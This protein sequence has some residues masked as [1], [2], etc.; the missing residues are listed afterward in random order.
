MQGY[1]RGGINDYQPGPPA[2]W[3]SMPQQPNPPS[4]YPPMNQG[5]L[6]ID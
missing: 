5:L 1:G 6:V 3:G 4:Y 2:S